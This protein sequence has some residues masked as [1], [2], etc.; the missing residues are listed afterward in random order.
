MLSIRKNLVFK[1]V[2]DEDFQNILLGDRFGEIEGEAVIATLMRA[3][4]LAVEKN[5][6]DLI[7]GVNM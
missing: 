4:D 7:G 3:K 2:D 5:G 6:S 1:L